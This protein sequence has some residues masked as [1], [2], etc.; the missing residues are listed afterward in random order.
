M[1]RLLR[2]FAVFLAAAIT[3]PAAANFH[4][5]HMQEVYSSADGK[6]QFLRF[7]TST[8][9]Q[10]FVDGHELTSVSGATTN[11]FSFPG[12]LPGDSAGHSFL[13]GTTSFA[14]LNIVHP[15]FTVPDN[16]FFVAGGTV[17]VPGMD[18]WTYPVLPG[19]TNSLNRNGATGPAT[20][21][22]FAGQTG[23]LSGLPVPT[24]TV[25]GP[26]TSTQGDNVTFMAT[27]SGGNNPTGT[28]QFSDGNSNFGTPVAVAGGAASTSTASLSLGTHQIKASYSGDSNNAPASSNVLNHTVS[29]QTTPPPPPSGGSGSKTL[30]SRATVTPGATLF[31]GFEIS[32]QSTVYILVRGN[33]LGT[34]GVTQGF[35]DSPLVRLFDGQGHDLISTG[36]S[37]GFTGCSANA[38]NGGPVVNFYTNTRGQPANARDGCTAQTLPAGV[39]T[40]TVTPSSGSSPTSGEVLFEVT[41]GAGTG[42]ITKTLG[43]RATVNPNATLFGGFELTQSS[44]VYMLVRGNSLGTLGVTSAFLDSPRVRLFDS[45]G[46]DLLMESPTVP[47]FTGCGNANSGGP[48]VTFYT[49]TRNQPPDV[50]D[51]C[52]SRVFPVGVYTFT[53]TPS[54]SGAVSSPSS[55][56]V[57]FEVTLG[58]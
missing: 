53:V 42:T 58:H 50:R 16:F 9:G 17:S 18:S 4:L 52:T 12:N 14:A 20:P 48:V 11:N 21:R 33:S 26:A 56:E 30:G 47:G 23:S 19:G 34:L 25:S 24:V 46:H 55:G 22:N 6:V 38:N 7:S 3:L 44:N 2:A 5:W 51:A 10:Q 40:F 32:A 28:V 37:P 36:N 15:D 13:V 43:S 29:A 1:I 31:G 27:L 49:T 41:L 45:G 8:G 39:Y 57:L 54:T 35:L